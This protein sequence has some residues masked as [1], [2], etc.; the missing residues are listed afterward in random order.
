MPFALWLRFCIKADARLF[1]HQWMFL[2]DTMDAIYPPDPWQPQAVADRIS[3]ILQASKRG[4]AMRRRDSTR[5]PLGSPRIEATDM[6]PTTKR[7]PLLHHLRQGHR[8]KS[9][10][11][12]EPFF[13]R[14]SLANYESVYAGRPVDH[15]LILASI[16]GDIFES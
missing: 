2:T 8:I 12:L 6:D 4:T 5:A 1:R 3:D 10:D 9:I 16:E 11:A 14:I 7:K 15:D 13:S